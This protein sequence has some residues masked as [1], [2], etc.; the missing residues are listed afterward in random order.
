MAHLRDGAAL[1]CFLAWLSREAPKGGVTERSAADRLEA[2]RKESDLLR[3]SVFRHDIG[4]RSERR[5]R[6]LPGRRTHQSGFARRRS[7]FGRFRG[8]VSGWHDRCDAH[9]RGRCSDRG[10]APSLHAGA[11]GPYRAWQPRGFPWARTGSQ[12]D[13]LARLPL[14]REGLDYDHGT[15]HGVGAY[16]SV[17]EGPQRISKVPNRIALAPGMIVSNEPGYYE[18]GAYG[19]RIE[20]LVA[21]VEREAGPPATLGFETLTLAPLDRAL[22]DTELCGAGRDRL[23]RRLSRQGAHGAGADRGCGNEGMAG[24]GGG[25]AGHLGR[26]VRYT[27]R[28]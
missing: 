7:V 20:N 23:G 5:D 18:T 16:L 28:H 10:H 9:N 14:W 15:G 24:V 19:I 27:R 21:V 25:A 3:D 12:L 2:F 1:T 8:A 13:I 26:L 4:C 6:A 11:E 22:I 17:H